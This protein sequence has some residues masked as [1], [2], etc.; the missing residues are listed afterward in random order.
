M[1]FMCVILYLNIDTLGMKYTQTVE[2]RPIIINCFEGLR[3]IVKIS[4]LCYYIMQQVNNWQSFVQR[5][6]NF[7]R[8]YYWL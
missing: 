8:Y 6:A 4:I 7:F 5:Q 3:K 1:L 2:I